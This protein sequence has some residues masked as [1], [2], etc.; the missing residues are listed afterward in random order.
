M[1]VEGGM[2]TVTQQ[3]ADAAQKAGAVIHTNSHVER[4]LIE[5]N[6]ARG[7]RLSNGQEVSATGVL[8]ATSSLRSSTAGWTT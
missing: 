4:I 5:N 2:G 1:V 8:E 7:V 3:L 6:V